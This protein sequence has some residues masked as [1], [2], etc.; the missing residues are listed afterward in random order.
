MSLTVCSQE[1]TQS[2]RLQVRTLCIALFSQQA[3]VQEHGIPAADIAK[4]SA[5]HFYNVEAVA[6]AS[7]RELEAI[8][9]LATNKIE[10][11]QKAG[12]HMDK[13]NVSQVSCALMPRVVMGVD[14]VAQ[15]LRLLFCLCQPGSV[16]VVVL[17]VRTIF[18]QQQLQRALLCSME[19]GA[20]GLHISHSHC[21]AR[22]K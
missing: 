15:C 21:P 22:G 18:P 11:I 10:K 8:K 2:L 9:G 5:A 7:K 16:R 20:H 4:L 3:V 17:S 19:Y 6:R 14:N 13:S 1:A 12:T